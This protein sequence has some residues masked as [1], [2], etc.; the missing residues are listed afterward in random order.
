M[1]CFIH[2]LFAYKICKILFLFPF[3]K[4]INYLSDATESSCDGSA[5]EMEIDGETPNE[6][7]AEDDNCDDLFRPTRSGRLAGGWRLASFIGKYMNTY[8]T[9][10]LR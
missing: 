9:W 10:Y 1:F 7:I 4:V 2:S 5:G 6:D 8:I 3:A